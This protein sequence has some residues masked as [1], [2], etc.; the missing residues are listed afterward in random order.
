MDISARLLI[1]S[2]LRNNFSSPQ[3]IAFVQN[4]LL[5]EYPCKKTIY[6]WINKLQEGETSINDKERSEKM[7]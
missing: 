5:E 7:Y 2:C 6:N 3:I 1:R 4:A